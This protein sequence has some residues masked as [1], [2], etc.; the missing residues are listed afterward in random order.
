MVL[1]GVVGIGGLGFGGR[2]WL[3]CFGSGERVGFGLR[4]FRCPGGGLVE[5]VVEPESV[6]GWSIWRSRW[7]GVWRYRELL[8]VPEGLEPV[9]LGE[10]GTPLVRLSTVRGVEAYGK[11]EGCNPTGSFKDRGMTVA[12]TLARLS[13][14]RAVV[15]ASTGNTAASS[16]AYAARAGLRS[17]VVVPEG[18]VA[19]G[20]LAQT[21]HY[22]ASIVMVTGG[23]DE[24]L[25]AVMRAVEEDETLY[26]LNSFN[27]WRLEGQKTV[28]YE[29]VDQLGG[30][31]DWIVLPVGNAGNISAVWKGLRELYKYGLI[32]RLPRLAGIQAEGAAPLADM[33]LQGAREP[34]WYDRPETV[35]SAIRIG[36]PVNWPK[37]VAA[38][39]E[40]R[41]VFASVPDSLIMEAHKYLARREGITVEPASAAS[42]AG[43]W[44]LMDEGVIDRGETVALILTGHG[45][46]DP[47]NMMVHPTVKIRAA[48]P[49]EA[50]QAV[51]SLARPAGIPEGRVEAVGG[52]RA[53]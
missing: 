40:S 32:D 43:L 38:V 33:W 15:V 18:K 8:P 29:I 50:V 24:A 36:R 52:V 5:V 13:G 41:G 49:F 16:A 34:L 45:L 46:K 1:G 7:P 47:E 3:R 2:V 48:T 53:G 25:E 12:V 26:P 20:K 14:A 35:A 17:I 30:V 23:F 21:V 11:L 4:V 27:P 39:R 10:G 6:P 31:P 42:L 9:S 51:K 22:G 28:A 19:G 44:K 37:A